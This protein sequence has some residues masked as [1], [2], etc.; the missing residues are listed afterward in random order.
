MKMLIDPS[1]VHAHLDK[2]LGQRIWCIGRA[3]NMLWVG[4]GEY[5]TVKNYR[6]EEREVNVYNLHVQCAWRMVSPEG[7]VVGFSD[8]YHPASKIT[9]YEWDW[10]V[11]GNNLF[12]EISARLTADFK[13]ESIIVY[14]IN[15]SPYGDLSIVLSNGCQL[16]LFPDDALD[17]EHWRFMDRSADD[18]PNEGDFVVLRDGYY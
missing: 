17:G 16:Q 1:E 4:F 14:K 2:L 10:D 11:Q 18:D 6:G 5:I 9:T 3:A 13:Q 7:I 8:F 12:D 15:D